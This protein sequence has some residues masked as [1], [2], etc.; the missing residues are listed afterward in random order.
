MLAHK[1]YKLKSNVACRAKKTAYAV[2]RLIPRRGG[3]VCFRFFQKDSSLNR[4]DVDAA[5]R[6]VAQSIHQHFNAFYTAC[7]LPGIVNIHS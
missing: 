2:R 3:E 4:S 7:R 1:R 5:A 6:H